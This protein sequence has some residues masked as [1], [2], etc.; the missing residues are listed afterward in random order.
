MFKIVPT[1][2]AV[3]DFV[4]DLLLQHIERKPTT[5]LGLATGATMEPVYAAMAQKI[6][7]RPLDVG[8][9]TTF[10][11]DEY[12][13]LPAQH[14]QS[15][16]HF[17]QRH[18][19]EP[20]GLRAQQVNLPDGTCTDTAQECAAYSQKIDAAGGLDV[21]LLGI[22]SNGHIGFNEPGT[23]FDCTT[24]AVELAPQT[25]RDNE[26]FFAETKM[27]PTHAITMG[28][29]E[30]MAANEVVLVATGA[31]KAEILAQLYESTIDERLPASI[32]KQH[33]NVKVVLDEAAAALL[34]SH[35]L[36]AG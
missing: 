33:P 27:V 30:I 21:Q 29:S 9:L 14:P 25:R 5:V 1:P 24:H 12:L 35:L 4:S 17:M 19:V 36:Q 20:I 18:F 32:L 26:R 28:I 6:Q 2:C 23:P 15:Y 16:A 13:G 34:P 11:L 3:A 31:H 10:N 8:R 7:Q 22:G